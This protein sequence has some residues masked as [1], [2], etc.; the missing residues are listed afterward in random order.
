MRCPNNSPS[1]S[2]PGELR[3][4]THKPAVASLITEGNCC[5]IISMTE[6]IA[7]VAITIIKPPTGIHSWCPTKPIPVSSY[8]TTPTNILTIDRSLETE[9]SFVA[10][11]VKPPTS[12]R[13]NGSQCLITPLSS[14]EC[15][16]PAPERGPPL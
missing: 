14:G 16:G 5:W 2:C 13:T 4:S 9:A 11:M 6:G 1:D 12:I 3:G 10:D 7:R 15:Y 8:I